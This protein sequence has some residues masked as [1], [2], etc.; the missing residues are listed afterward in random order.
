MTREQILSKI[1]ENE[2]AIRA[3]GVQHLPITAP[4]RGDERP[5]SDLD[6]II[7]LVPNDRFS[8]SD[9]GSGRFAKG[10]DAA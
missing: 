10:G 4:A 1:K 8:L 5:D 6:V 7:N 9:R 2:N 3:E